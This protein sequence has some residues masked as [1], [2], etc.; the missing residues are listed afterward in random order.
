[1]KNVKLARGRFFKPRNYGKIRKIPLKC[2][3]EKYFYEEAGF[4][5]GRDWLISHGCCWQASLHNINGVSVDKSVVTR[6]FLESNPTFP[7]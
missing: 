4:L 2:Y 6:G 5:Q 3:A 1:M 7:L